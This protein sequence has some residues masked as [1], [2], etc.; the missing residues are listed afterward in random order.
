MRSINGVTRV[1]LCLAIAAVIAAVALTQSSDK[2]HAEASVIRTWSYQMRA[3]PKQLGSTSSSGPVYSPFHIR[4]DSVEARGQLNVEEKEELFLLNKGDDL[5][6]VIPKVAFDRL[7]FRPREKGGGPYDYSQYTVELKS[8]NP[9][10]LLRGGEK[11]HSE[12]ETAVTTTVMRIDIKP[13][14]LKDLAT[15]AG[16]LDKKDVAATLLSF[17][18]D[19]KIDGHQFSV[20]GRAIY[21][22]TEKSQMEFWE[23][24]NKGVWKIWM[25]LSLAVVVILVVPFIWFG[26]KKSQR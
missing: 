1:V 8:N 13:Q 6:L 5:V 10:V 18:L 2:L 24:Q 9:D 17:D 4:I 3:E 26:I 22:I 14:G 25:L 12:C 20:E 15:T 16:V 21:D 7:R 11:R 23:S 19:G